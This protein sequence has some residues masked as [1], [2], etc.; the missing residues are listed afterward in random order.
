MNS[1]TFESA[2][3]VAERAEKEIV[4]YLR[5]LPRTIGVLNVEK[6]KHYQSKDIDIL[7]V[8]RNSEQSFLH[9]IEIKGD[10]YS[11]SGNYF[12]ETVSN[13]TLGTLGCFLYTE[14]DYLFYYFVDSGELSIM[15]VK[16]VRKW[17]LENIERFPERVV[18]TPVGSGGYKSKGRLVP[19][20]VMAKETAVKTIKIK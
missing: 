15:E 7:Y 14:A 17:F 6:D 20:D 1:Y 8:W 12:I 16:P 3:K 13:E 2:S 4:S 10:R 19:R 5:S 18:K 9:S 11:N